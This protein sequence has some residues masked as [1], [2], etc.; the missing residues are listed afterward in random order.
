MNLDALLEP[1]VALEGTPCVIVRTIESL[2]EQYKKAVQKLIEEG[3]ADEEM[4]ARF[5][6]AGLPGRASS[7]QRHRIG[8]CTCGTL[9]EETK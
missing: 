8:R 1:T 5:R 2:P 3:T 7:F 6:A 9:K 4:A